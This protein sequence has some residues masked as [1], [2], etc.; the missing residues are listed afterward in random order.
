MPHKEYTIN[1][2]DVIFLLTHMTE[3]RLWCAN[4]YGMYACMY[5]LNICRLPSSKHLT[6]LES[7]VC[8]CGSCGRNRDETMSNKYLSCQRF[9]ITAWYFYLLPTV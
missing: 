1:N 4:M 8:V 2:S 7:F 3:A 9:E 6:T 5:E